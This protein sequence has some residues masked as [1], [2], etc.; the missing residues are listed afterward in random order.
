MFIYSK[1][2]RWWESDP[3][4][5]LYERVTLPTELHRRIS[6]IVVNFVN[7]GKLAGSVVSFRVSF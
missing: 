1:W 5:T 7:Y 6:D 2:S 3:R 4:L